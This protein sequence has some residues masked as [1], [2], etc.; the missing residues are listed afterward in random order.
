MSEDH[1]GAPDSN[2]K[3]ELIDRNQPDYQIEILKEWKT[4]PI[5]HDIDFADYKTLNNIK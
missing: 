3:F 1:E 2:L 4:S 5:I